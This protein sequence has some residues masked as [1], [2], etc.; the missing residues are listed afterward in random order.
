[1][2]RK[3]Y[4]VIKM[5]SFLL[6]VIGVNVLF[7]VEKKTVQAKYVSHTSKQNIVISTMNN[8]CKLSWKPTHTLSIYQSKYPYYAGTIYRGIPY[9]QNED[10]TTLD[11]VKAC[12]WDYRSQ[13]ACYVYSSTKTSVGNDCSSAVAISLHQNNT[14]IK[15]E[16]INTDTFML[17]ASSGKYTGNGLNLKTVGGY[18][19]D[20]ANT[21]EYI[22][23]IGTKE[24]NVLYDKIKPGDFL[25][26]KYGDNGHAV[27][28]CDV[29]YANKKVII[30]DQIGRKSGDTNSSWRYY[31]KM[32][33]N[34]LFNDY[35]LPLRE[36]SVT[37]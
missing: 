22:S 8:M 32:S 11:F 33:Y 37:P 16:K 1:M 28:V 14:S 6:I 36:N 15:Y 35:Y 9:N 12:N 24:A 26:Y 5:M 20:S 10:F 27:L 17:C 13:L 23:K 3:L 4:G 19:T 30:T 25:F 2:K 29:D 21:K 31:K 34:S 7:C 18:K